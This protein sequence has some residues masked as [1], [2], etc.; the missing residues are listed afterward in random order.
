MAGHSWA[1]PPEGLGRPTV[2]STT[3]RP[4][5][6]ISHRGDVG[7]SR[8]DAYLDLDLSEGDEEDSTIAAAV[9]ASRADAYLDADFLEGDE[10]DSTIAAVQASRADKYENGRLIIAIDYGNTFTSNFHAPLTTDIN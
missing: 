1:S 3:S 6:N 8:A 9:H 2:V 7:S 10:E 5:L 4:T